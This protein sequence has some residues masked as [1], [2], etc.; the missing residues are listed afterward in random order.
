MLA[1]MFPLLK[2]TRPLFVALSATLFVNEAVV[3]YALI[4]AY[5]GAANL[6][7]N[8]AVP[9]VSVINLVML[10]Y[11]SILMWDELKGRRTLSSEPA[12]L[13][14]NVEGGG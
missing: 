8:L 9:V 7:G 5:P 10:F 12:E 1:L 6:N 14:P 13:N 3:L 2:K 4:G 11:A